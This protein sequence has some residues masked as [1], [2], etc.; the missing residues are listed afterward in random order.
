MDYK[1][2]LK[3]KVTKNIS[4]VT[5]NKEKTLN[6]LSKELIEE[7]GKIFD[8]L[9]KDKEVKLVILTGKN[10]SF[11]A[12]A[13]IGEMAT[14]N[15]KEGYYWSKNGMNIFSKIEK[16]RFPVIAA[17]NG[18][19]LG[20]GCEIALACDIRIASEKAKFG[21]PEVGLGITPGFGGTQRL[22]RTI[23]PGMAKELI[24]TA[25]IINAQ[26]ALR[27]GLVNH[28]YESEE[29]I[30]KAIEL[31]KEIEKNAKIA[32][33]FSKSAINNGIQADIETGLEIERTSF[34]LCFETKDQKEGMKAFLEKRKPDFKGN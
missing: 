2:L 17:I 25:K 5:I 15:A 9:E 16:S 28:V 12:G 30:D 18:F 7:L 31:A 3:E 32:V 19:A 34:G 14:L 4:L 21:Q 26:E 8:E 27:I 33:E 24:Y 22:I 13:D 10:R 29:L 23:G 1:Y 11:V 6:A 20:G